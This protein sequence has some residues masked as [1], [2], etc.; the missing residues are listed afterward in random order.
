MKIGFYLKW[1]KGMFNS[2]GWNVIGD[3]LHGESMCKAISKIKDIEIAELYA[4]NNLPKEKLDVMIY[5]NDTEPHQ[6]WAKKHILYMQN[7]YGEGSDKILKN[8][9]NVGYDGYAFISNKLLDIHKQEGHDGIFLPFG[10]DT[11]L[12]YPREKEE[13][14]GFDVAYVGNDIKGEVRTNKYLLPAAQFNFGLFGNW[15]IPESNIR[16][17]IKFWEKREKIPHYRKI[18]SKLSRG[19]I[20]QEKVPILYSSAK[21][22]LNCTAQDCVDWDVITLRTFEVL[23]CRGFLITDKVPIAEKTMQGCM[24]FTDGDDDLIEKIGYYLSNEKEREKIAGKGYEYALKNAAIDSRM[25]E[26]FN[27]LRQII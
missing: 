6:E 8:F 25:N 17:R 10:V 5:L 23:A 19:K 20:P 26:L 13:E 11:E 1:P 27:Y 24:V 2:K 3:E 14:F 7:A 22:N 21:I 16:S 15:H 4:P 12:F 18:F 9:Q